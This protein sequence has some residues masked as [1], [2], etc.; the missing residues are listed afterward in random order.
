[1]EFNIPSIFRKANSKSKKNEKKARISHKG[2]LKKPMHG[3]E[4]GVLQWP[5]HDP[6]PHR[7]MHGTFTEAGRQKNALCGPF[8]F[9][10]C[11]RVEYELKRHYIYTVCPRYATCKTR[12]RRRGFG[13]RWTKM[14]L[15]E[16]MLF[17]GATGE[18]GKRTGFRSQHRKVCGFESR[19]AH[20][21]P[22][23][24]RETCPETA[25]FLP[26]V[27][28]L[29]SRAKTLSSFPS[30]PAKK[31]NVLAYGQHET[32]SSFKAYRMLPTPMP[33]QTHPAEFLPIHPLF[34]AATVFFCG[35]SV[36]K[37]D[38]SLAFFRERVYSK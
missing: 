24:K 25:P 23:Q 18:I 20:H 27:F 34:H 1:M 21:L 29:Q 30:A 19:V 14:I 31:G 35:I 26:P 3:K 28:Y 17:L 12:I 36:E 6:L 9:F 4:F 7:R 10:F 33:D 5:L 2:G 16:Q 8:P 15:R 22:A 13:G 37:K 32:R 11:F 38:S